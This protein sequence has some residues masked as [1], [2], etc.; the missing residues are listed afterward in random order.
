MAA[1]GLSVSLHV[2][3]HRTGTTHF[4][5]TLH[6]NRAVMTRDRV[7]MW[8]PDALRGAGQ[9]LSDRLGFERPG[10]RRIMP[11]PGQGRAALARLVEP[12]T[13]CLLISEENYIGAF[14]DIHNHLLLPLYPCARMHLEALVRAMHP[15][16]VDVFIALR[17]PCDYLRGCYS[18][19]LLSGASVR[20]EVFFLDYGP[21]L[22]DWEGL[23]HS[24]RS[25]P[26]LRGLTVW[27]YEDY[28]ANLSQLVSAM[29]GLSPET[30]FD[31][32]QE[33]AHPS[34]SAEAVRQILFRMDPDLPRSFRAELA[35]EARGAL[36]VQAGN[37][38]FDPFPSDQ[39]AEMA[40]V[41]RAQLARIAA[42][43]GV[44]FLQAAAP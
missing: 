22:V 32:S 40:V 20:P 39:R 12:E 42:M 30:R 13:R 31:V 19:I 35:R 18:Q 43:P 33:R 36:P 29:T 11:A 7:A 25:V 34:L 23:I 26:G 5:H 3:V 15:V 10:L 27:R 38:P 37:A 41:Y 4:Q 24:I 9:E 8:L 44:T 28:P 14:R 6:A 2:G 21:E 17:D 1:T 16:P